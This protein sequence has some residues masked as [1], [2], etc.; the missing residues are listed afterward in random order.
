[1]YKPKPKL[2]NSPPNIKERVFIVY[3]TREIY[4]FCCETCIEHQ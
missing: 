2:N 4:V 1:M 3:L